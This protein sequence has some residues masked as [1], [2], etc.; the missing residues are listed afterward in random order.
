MFNH[1]NKIGNDDTTNIK[2]DDGVAWV[3]PGC[4]W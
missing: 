4:G 3:Q 2:G 1:S